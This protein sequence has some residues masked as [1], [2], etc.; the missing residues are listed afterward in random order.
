MSV[1]YEVETA[2]ADNP[3]LP[4]QRALAVSLAAEMD[5][6]PNASI[7]KELAGLMTALGAANVEKKGDVSDD[8]ASRR[9]ARRKAASS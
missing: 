9:A 3:G 7:A 5:E 2:L 8:L 1:L 4:W 6:K